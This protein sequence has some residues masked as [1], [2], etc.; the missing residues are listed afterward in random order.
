MDRA[1]GGVYPAY[2]VPVAQRTECVAPARQFL[3]PRGETGY[4]I[5]LRN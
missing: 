5:S 4:H 1:L 3:C 2:S